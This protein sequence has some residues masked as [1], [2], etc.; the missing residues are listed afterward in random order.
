[1]IPELPITMLACARIGAIH[2]VVFGG[3][4][5]VSLANRIQDSDC[6]LLVTSNVSLRGGKAIRLKDIADEALESCP[7]VKDVIVVQRTADQVELREG[8][9][10]W[11]H[12]EMAD[13]SPVS[14]PERMNAEDPLFIL[15]TSGSTGRPKG[16]LHTTGGYLTYVAMTHKYIFDIHEEDTF[17]CTADIGWITGH[18]YIVY[19]PLAGGRD[20]AHVRGHSHLSRCQPLLAD[21]GQVRG[22][23]LLY[24]TY[25][26][27]RTGS[28]WQRVGRK[29]RSVQFAPAGHGR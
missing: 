9:D 20:V 24:R 12:D 3:F 7:S 23:H 25:G 16:V 6:K 17:W 10:T 26:D 18:S 14:E 5:A 4:S 21:R 19:G 1:M 13:A 11:W 28:A 29:V 2:S 15:Y 22:E 27:P 8:R